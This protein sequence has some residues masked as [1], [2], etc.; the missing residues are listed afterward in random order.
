MCSMGIRGAWLNKPGL[1]W[2]DAGMH[3]RPLA[4]LHRRICRPWPPAHAMAA[5]TLAAAC[6][7][8]GPPEA[9]AQPMRR[10]LVETREV[11]AAVG[12]I[13]PEVLGADQ[14][15]AVCAPRRHTTR[16][17][18]DWACKVGALRLAA[19][20]QP[21]NGDV[22][23]ADNKELQARAHLVSLALD[24]ADALG[25]Y[26][27][28]SGVSRDLPAQQVAAQAE[29]CTA[30]QELFLALVKV[31]ENKPAGPL[32]TEGFPKDMA[33]RLSGQ[34]LKE[35][36]CECHQR[37][38]AL[39]RAGLLSERDAP[40]AVAQRN[41]LGL[42]CN[43]KGTG[44]ESSRVAIDRKAHDVD[45]SAVGGSARGADVDKDEAQRVADRR[46]AELKLCVDPKDRSSGAAA[47]MARCACPLMKRWRFPRRQGEEDL[48]VSVAISAK[49]PALNLVINPKGMVAN[50]TLQ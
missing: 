32:L 19:A 33:P 8:L 15:L 20:Q 16:A 6:A 28:L 44:R 40:M 3:S 4:R 37:V 12:R 21:V 13:K 49:L 39:G 22:A 42:G 9:R 38:Q 25:Y 43:L 7:L 47:K 48:Q 45:L 11:K 5:C 35:A 23:L 30:V 27:P 34:S 26:K 2:L 50:C 46:K 29:A 17:A 24:A 36:T 14:G 41:Y 31:P 18:A 10:A 1:G